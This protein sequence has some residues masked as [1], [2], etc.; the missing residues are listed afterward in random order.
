[1]SDVPEHANRT[2]AEVYPDEAGEWRSRVF[3]ANGHEL[4]KS[5]EGYDDQDDCVSVIKSRF[6]SILIDYLDAAP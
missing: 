1:V 5:S 2:R 4:F 6:G 3:D